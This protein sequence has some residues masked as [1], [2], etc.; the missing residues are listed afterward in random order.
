MRA[1]R[2]NS[3]HR[4]TPSTSVRALPVFVSDYCFL[5]DSRDE[6][7]SPCLVGR[8]YPSRA[9]FATVVS[10]KGI[11]DDIAIKQLGTF[12]KENGVRN[13]VYKSDQENSLKAC[14]DE[15]IRSVG[16]TAVEADDAVLC[17]I[18]EY[19]AVV[20]S[21]SN[22]KAERSVQQLEDQVR[23]LKSALEE[24]IG[25]RLGST[26]SVMRWLVRHCST[27]LTRFS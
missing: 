17:A 1:R 4:H 10:E 11:N 21:A 8:I 15:A 23:T 16:G 13:L 14:I 20:E 26:H 9:M 3:H 19:S 25:A 7:V 2:P 5:R 18:P 27:I 22:G 6:D 12:F 24:R